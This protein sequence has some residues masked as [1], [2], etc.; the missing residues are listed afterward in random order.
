MTEQKHV[1]HT[2]LDIYFLSLIHIVGS[3]NLGSNEKWYPVNIE[4]IISYTVQP[5]HSY[6]PVT[7]KYFHLH[8]SCLFCVQ[9]FARFIGEILVKRYPRF[10]HFCNLSLSYS[11]CHINSNFYFTHFSVFNTKRQVPCPVCYLQP[12]RQEQC[13]IR[14]RRP[15][16]RRLLIRGS[17]QMIKGMHNL[18][19]HQRF[20]IH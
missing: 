11:S 12:D 8:V 9:W 3:L 16:L 6:V 17:T 5:C 1:L 7:S 20:Q 14:R 2:K 18:T 10:M 13:G 15:V 19:Y 4:N